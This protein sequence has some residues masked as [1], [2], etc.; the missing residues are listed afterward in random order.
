MSRVLVIRSSPSLVIRPP[1]V[2]TSV[3]EQP[4]CRMLHVQLVVSIIISGGQS[5]SAS[6]YDY[7]SNRYFLTQSNLFNCFVL[8][9]L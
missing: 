8:A 2:K 3:M 5:I 9:S 4:T 7:L 6:E 1:C